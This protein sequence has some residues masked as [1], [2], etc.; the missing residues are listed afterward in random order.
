MHGGDGEARRALVER[1][2]PYARVVAARLFARRPH[3]DVEFEEYRQLAHVGLLEAVD[4]YR[5]DRGARFTTFATPR[6]RGSILSGLERLTERRQQWAVRQC[7]LEDRVDAL[8]EQGDPALSTDVLEELE[9]IG[10]GMAFG[11]ILE[12]TG[13]TPAMVGAQPESAYSQLELQRVHR[14]LWEMVE[15]LTPRERQVV[16]LHYG[17]GERFEAIARDLGLTRG[18]ISQLHQQALKRLRSLMR[19]QDRFDVAY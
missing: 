4:R 3:D 5:L 6:I 17:D 18:R 8:L 2:L 15:H 16:Q 7:I 1:Y 10:V 13:V 14:R 11:L 12:G 9:A 19:R